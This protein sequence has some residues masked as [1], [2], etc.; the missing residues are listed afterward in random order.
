MAHRLEL[1]GVGIAGGVEDDE[2]GEEERH[3]VGVANDPAFMVFGLFGLGLCGSC[4]FPAGFAGV[5]AFAALAGLEEAFELFA[6]DARVVADW[7]DM[8]PSTTTLRAWMFVLGVVL[9]LVREGEP[10]HVGV[11]TP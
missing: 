7:M 10:E 8:R 6:D 9:E 11:K 2:E 4:G 3:H 5:I 1:L